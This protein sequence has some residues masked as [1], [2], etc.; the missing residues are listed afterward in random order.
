MTPEFTALAIWLAIVLAGLLITAAA[1]FVVL[2]LTAPRLEDW[3]DVNDLGAEAFIGTPQPRGVDHSPRG[4]SGRP[5]DPR[6]RR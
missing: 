3:D 6:G 5:H 4:R 2:A 1:A